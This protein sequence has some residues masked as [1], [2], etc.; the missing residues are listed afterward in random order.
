MIKIKPRCKYGG[1]D[2]SFNI[3]GYFLPCC[4]VDNPQAKKELEFF[5]IFH[6]DF[7]IDNLKTPE[8]IKSVFNSDEWNHFYNFVEENPDKAPHAC[9]SHCMVIDGEHISLTEKIDHEGRNVEINTIR[10]IDKL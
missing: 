9:K 2:P 1:R 7:F 6:E 8:D 4:W 10:I 3:D 5:G